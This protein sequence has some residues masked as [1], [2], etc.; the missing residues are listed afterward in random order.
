ME[1]VA[2]AFTSESAFMMPLMRESGSDVTL[3]GLSAACDGVSSSADEPGGR[4]GVATTDR[5][6]SEVPTTAAVGFGYTHIV[7]RLG[8]SGN[9]EQAKIPWLSA[10]VSSAQQVQAH[11]RW[12]RQALRRKQPVDARV[13]APRN[14]QS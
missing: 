6:I 12:G 2:I 1:S 11:Q 14:E 8:Q 4:T 7:G 5:S 3:R 13:L 9:L 10:Q